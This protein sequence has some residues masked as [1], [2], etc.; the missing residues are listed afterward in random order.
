M[1]VVSAALELAEKII[2]VEEIIVVLLVI[3]LFEEMV[4]LVA[5]ELRKLIKQ[6]EE[7]K[8]GWRT[9]TGQR[10]HD[11]HRFLSFSSDWLA[12]KYFLKGFS[13]FARRW[14]SAGEG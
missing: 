6:T 13:I 4:A 1:E 14:C 12:S 5:S 3:E 7:R 11:T 8:L 10:M 2:Q 9:V